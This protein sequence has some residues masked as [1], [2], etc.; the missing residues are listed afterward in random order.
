MTTDPNIAAYLSLENYGISGTL[1]H[2]RSAINGQ[3]GVFVDVDDE[4]GTAPAGSN[5]VAGFGAPSLAVTFNGG[6]DTVLLDNP[7]ASYEVGV[8]ANGNATIKDVGS[9]DATYGQTMT[10]SGASY[11]LFSGAAHTTANSLSPAP[12]YTGMMFV[13]TGANSNVAALYQIALARQPDLAGLEY[14]IWQYDRAVASGQ[15][16]EQAL[17][18]VAG[19]FLVS[20]EFNTRFTTAAAAADHGGVNDQAFV[21]QLYQNVLGRSPD[22]SGFAYWINLLSTGADSRADVLA[23]FATSPEFQTAMSASQGGWLVNTSTTGGYA[24]AGAQ[25]SAT[26]VLTT[27]SQTN[28]LNASLIDPTTLPGSGMVTVGEFGAARAGSTNEVVTTA[29]AT[30]VTLVLSSQF[31]VAVI[32]NDY[33]TVIAGQGGSDTIGVVGN[34]TTVDLHGTGNTVDFD[35]H[36]SQNN[37]TAGTVLPFAAPTTITGYVTGGAGNGGDSLTFPVPVYPPNFPPIILTPTAASP[38]SGAGLD[39]NNHLYVLNIGSAGDGSAATVAAAADAVYTVCDKTGG[40]PV[41]F[42][43]AGPQGEN[44]LIIGTTAAGNTVIYEFG[45]MVAT[46]TSPVVYY[47]SADTNHTG[48]VQ[49][50]DLQLIATLVGVNANSLSAHDFGG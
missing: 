28:Y 25:Q 36:F 22:P 18:T 1:N 47:T 23:G 27:A 4:N 43:Q 9:G 10:A 39:F 33:D 45:Q 46:A 7:R 44:L 20:P 30:G 17:S 50:A 8:D 42:T 35:R 26:T 49:A 14:W 31:T 32:R 5:A 16:T 48:H 12:V 3:T 13:E 38:V 6:Y 34:K 37:P 40:M 21:T 24:D 29:S 11:L 41:A 19:G 15:S 2:G